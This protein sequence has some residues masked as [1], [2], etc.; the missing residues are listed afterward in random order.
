MVGVYAKADSELLT[1]CIL[2]EEADMDNRLDL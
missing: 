2:R 1:R